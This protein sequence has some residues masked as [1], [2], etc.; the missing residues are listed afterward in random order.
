MANLGLPPTR[1]ISWLQTVEDADPNF[2]KGLLRPW[3]Y[4]FSNGRLFVK[5]PTVYTDNWPYQGP[6]DLIANWTAWY[7]LRGYNAA[8]TGKCLNVRRASDS[9]A[10]DIYIDIGGEIDFTTLFAFCASTTGFVTTLYDQTGNG[11]NL[12]QANT[13]NQPTILFQGLNNNPV[14][15]F[16]GNQ[17]LAGV[18]IPPGSTN[19]T[20]AVVVNGRNQAGSFGNVFGGA[21]TNNDSDLVLTFPPGNTDPN[22]ISFGSVGGFDAPAALGAWHSVI[23]VSY[24]AQ[25]AT[26][27][28]DGA[29][30]IGDIELP[31]FDSPLAMGWG[32]NSPG[33]PPY[34][35]GQIVESGLPPVA[36]T[37]QQISSLTSNQRAY[38][39]F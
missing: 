29:L 13:V 16:N 19:A 17:W 3:I 28:V 27:S 5:D 32:A 31:I 33:S 25:A 6:G 10:I 12:I 37:S 23:G 7:G 14:I 2:Q 20:L 38:W 35:I 22:S 8:Y 21:Q 18:A 34:F 15:S 30:T 24:A 9:T 11:L 39:S 4:Q 26:L 1:L 36:M